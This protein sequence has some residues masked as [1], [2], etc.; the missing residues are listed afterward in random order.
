MPS[1]A[2]ADLPT[3]TLEHIGDHFSF[4]AR[5]WTIGLSYMISGHLPLMAAQESVRS[6]AKHRLHLVNVLHETGLH[7]ETGVADQAEEWETYDY[8]VP[9]VLWPE[10]RQF[11]QET[12]DKSEK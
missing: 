10:I 3:I 5:G 8:E 11:L 4:V 2:A 9:E 6:E 12:L 7:V 1:F